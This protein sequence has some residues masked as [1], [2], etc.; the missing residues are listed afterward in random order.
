MKIT[1]FILCRKPEKTVPFWAVPAHT[2]TTGPLSF[3][4]GNPRYGKNI[5]RAPQWGYD[6]AKIE[7]NYRAGKDFFKRIKI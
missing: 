3:N 6:S 2:N 4:V 1:D 7:Q 5:E